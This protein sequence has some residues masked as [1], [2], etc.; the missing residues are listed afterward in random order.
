MLLNN[1]AI[2]ND[3]QSRAL[4]GNLDPTYNLNLGKRMTFYVGDNNVV[5]VSDRMSQP[6]SGYRPPYSLVI[7]PKAGA[8]SSNY[9]SRGQA[10]S[11]V[12]GFLG[13]FTVGQS[14]GVATVSGAMSLII[15]AIGSAGG[16][17]TVSGV[18]SASLSAVGSSAGVATA[19]ALI[20]A[21]MS[22]VGQS[23]GVATVTGISKGNGSVTANIFVNESQASVQQIT[24]GIL[25]AVAA[26]YNE[27]GTIGQKINGAGS[28]GDPWTTDLSGYN[29]DGT[30]GKRL[31]DTLSTGKFLALK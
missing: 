7:A 19:D 6:G 10:S 14:D 28:A 22:A 9:I 16:V 26:D 8:V 29:T 21:L 15:K 30:A 25:N 3:N 1:Y 23:D 11:S 31:K 5:N 18:I 12:A 24:D 17:A 13:K 27:S 2:R 4:G 20:S